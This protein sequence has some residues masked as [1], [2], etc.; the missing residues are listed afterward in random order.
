MDWFEFIASLVNSLAWPMAVV[1]LVLILRKPLA[2][3]IPLLQ[4]LKYKDL[5]LEF[6]R[7]VEEVSEKLVAAIPRPTLKYVPSPSESRA[8]QLAEVSPRAAVMEAWREV[9]RAVIGAAKRN[10]LSTGKEQ[11][12]VTSLRAI[13]SLEQAEMVERDKAR[14]LNDVRVLRNQAAHAPEF[15]LSKDSAIEYVNAAQQLTSY[16]DSL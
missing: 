16:L 15:A 9:E 2:G 12:R 1:I 3:L 5:E 4:R 10:D 13:R 6:G 11:G 14:L 7:R 8:I